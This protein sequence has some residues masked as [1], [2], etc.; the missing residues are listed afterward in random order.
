MQR[1]V[2][3]TEAEVARQVR[4][5]GGDRS[6]GYLGRDGMKIIYEDLI[7]ST[8]KRLH[9]DKRFTVHG[10]VQ[11]S[12]D[13]NILSVHLDCIHANPPHATYRV[14]FLKSDMRKMTDKQVANNV[15]ASLRLA[16]DGLREYVAEMEKT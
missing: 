10:P 5:D 9:F 16:E 8:L 7:R 1:G 12:Y 15:E 14:E 2:Q 6:Y 4:R 3:A 11:D 13:P